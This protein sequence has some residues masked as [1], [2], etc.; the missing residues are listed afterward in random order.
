MLPLIKAVAID[1]IGPVSVVKTMQL[2]K[3]HSKDIWFPKF[4]KSAG[5]FLIAVIIDVGPSG[6]SEGLSIFIIMVRLRGNKKVTKYISTILYAT[7]TNKV[8]LTKVGQC[9]NY[10]TL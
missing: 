4:N 8:Y 9:G 5:H 6:Y 10:T 2:T 1:V 3:I 7:T